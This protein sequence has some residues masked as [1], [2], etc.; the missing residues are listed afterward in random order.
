M[1]LIVWSGTRNCS[2]GDRNRS[3]CSLEGTYNDIWSGSIKV[4]PY[5]PPHENIVRVLQI[6]IVKIIWVE[7]LCILVEGLELALDTTSKKDYVSVNQPAVEHLC[8]LWMNKLTQCLRSTSSSASHFRV[9]KGRFLLMIS[10]AKNVVRVGYSCEN[11]CNRKIVMFC[12]LCRSQPDTALSFLLFVSKWKN[13]TEN[14]DDKSVSSMFSFHNK[15][16]GK[17][18]VTHADIHCL[19]SIT[20]VVLYI[21]MIL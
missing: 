4:V 6:L 1:S 14:A 21:F 9:R 13:G 8:R 18:W 7:C 5:L 15:L 19:F 11:E 3:S 20:V 10:P 16:Q 2:W 17:K 12:L